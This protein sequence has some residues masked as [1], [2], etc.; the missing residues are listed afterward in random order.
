MKLSDTALI[1]LGGAAQRDDRLVPRRSTVPPVVD[2]NACR[3]LVKQDFV[4][5]VRAPA[6]ISDIVTVR[7]DDGPVAFVISDA[8]FRALNLDQPSA[9]TAATGVATALTHGGRRRG[10][11]WRRHGR[12]GRHRR[13]HGGAG[14]RGERRRCRRTR[15][16]LAA[17]KARGRALGGDRGGRPLARPDAA[18]AATARREMAEQAAHRLALEI[19]RLE[20]DGVLGQASLARALTERDVPTPGGSATW[21]HTTVAR[22]LVRTSR[23]SPSCPVPGSR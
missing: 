5:V 10:G 15:A 1:V 18:A 12:R 14:Q 7:E 2:V 23:A 21:T 20:Q 8:G 19:A 6:G 9:E 11:L 16:A 17:A 4:E 22:I 13:A 3:A